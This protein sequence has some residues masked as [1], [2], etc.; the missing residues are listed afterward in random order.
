MVNL[1]EKDLAKKRTRRFSL[2]EMLRVGIIVGL[3]IG[4]TG[5][6][7]TLGFSNE[8]F[9]K[10]WKNLLLG[11][12]CGIMGALT[13]SVVLLLRGRLTFHST[14]ESQGHT[15]QAGGEP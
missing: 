6:G 14:R 7:T 13:W 3:L 15:D 5:T 12:G 10:T 2:W 8:N 11:T 1:N 9:V 4:A